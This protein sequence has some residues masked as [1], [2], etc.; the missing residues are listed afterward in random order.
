MSLQNDLR[1]ATLLDAYYAAEY[2]WELDGE[3]RQLRIGQTA[4]ELEAFFPKSKRFGLLS[5]W[6][7]Q[8]IPRADSVNRR[9]DEALH[10]A[11]I[12]SGLPFR[13]GF[14]SAPN[15]S[16]REP[17][18][19]VMDMTDVDFDGLALRYGQ[20]GTLAW[21]RGQPVRLRMYAAQPLTAKPRDFVDWTGRVAPPRAPAGTASSGKTGAPTR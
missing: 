17:S 19:V 15:R 11:L 20:L 4:A 18:W 3:W 14:C 1:I 2:R 5:A 6:D 16:W 21:Q 8:S 9:A 7:P 12:A 10:T 13:P